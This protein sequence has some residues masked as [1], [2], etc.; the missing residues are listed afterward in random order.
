MP[1]NGI[2]PFLRA[3]KRRAVVVA[4]DILAV[5]LAWVL[6]YLTRYN[7]SPYWVDWESCLSALPVIIVVQS[8]VL[9]WTGLYRGLWRFASI[10]DLLNII[11]AVGYGALLVALTLFLINRL[12]GVPRSILLLYPIF[13]LLL[14]AGPR[15]AYRMWKDRRLTLAAGPHRKRVLILGAG[16]AGDL[17]A[18]DMLGEANYL[19]VAFLDDRRDLVGRQVRRIPV[20]GVLEQLPAKAD[21]MAADVAVIAMPSANSRQMRRAVSL[22][23]QAGIPYRTLPRLQDLVSGQASIK[24]LRE[25]AID[26]LLGRDEVFLD[27]DRIRQSLAGKSLLVSGGGGSIG[28]EL[29]RQLAR[30]GPAA[31]IV[32]DNNEY[33]LYRIEQELRQGFLALNLYTYLCDVGDETSVKEI[34]GRHLPEVVFHAAAYKHVPLL[35]RQAR[36][37]VGNNILGTRCLAEAAQQIGCGAFILIS[38][39]KA[40]NPTS[41]MGASK[42]VAELLCQGLNRRSGTRFIVVRFGNVLGSAGSVVPLFQAQITAG[43]PVT[44]THPEMTRYFMTIPEACHLITQAAVIGKGGEIF[45]LDMG[46]S[47][48]ITELA[49]EMIRLS[50]QESEVEIV[51][52]GLRPGEKLHEELFYEHEAPLPTESPKILLAQHG[53]V[54]W[55]RLER[56]LAELE[57]VWRLGDELQV[58]QAL[59]RILSKVGAEVEFQ[60]AD[61]KVIAINRSQL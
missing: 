25:V 46:E 60:P 24:E 21:E 61:S 48:K 6:G 40:V 41:V 43:G 58:K 16:R 1:K 13:S 56:E 54:E 27:W 3:Q 57:G 39:D 45:V 30:L 19:P 49:E 38:T 34:L 5:C 9:I 8:V 15:L 33:R 20:V 51:Y 18:R 14:L 36:Q 2:G 35:E 52:T 55:Q 50:G 44:V 23:E 32:I 59:E 42:R 22:C 28:S 47:I 12:H 53:V 29:C 26:D 10:P 31:L 7:L 4:H 37:A 11:R 17:L